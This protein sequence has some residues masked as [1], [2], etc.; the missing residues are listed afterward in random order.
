MPTVD[1]VNLSNQKVGEI[2]LAE[3]VFGAQVNEALVWEAVRH[4]MAC[5]RSGTHKTK[6]RWEV[7]GSG[8][9]LWR[10]KGTGRARMGSIRSPIWR[11]GGT[12]HGPIPRD[13]SYRLP[14]K[15]LLGAL[16]S[17]LTAKL[18]DGELKVVDALSIPE[19]KTKAV[20]SAL[21]SLDVNRTV[22][23]VEAGENENLLLG[24]RNIPGVTVSDSH[25]VTTYDLLRHQ[26]VVLTQAAA[27]KLSEGLA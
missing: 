3:S 26:V 21:K 15:M 1:V 18:R 13:Y 10:Q 17:A 16:R 11:H 12:V 6:R 5:R 23:L 25:D 2:S 24:A 14:K 8:K 7:S 4:Y 19:A 20:A 27:Q 22:L 9:K